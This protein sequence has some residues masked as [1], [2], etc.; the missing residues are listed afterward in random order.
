MVRKARNSPVDALGLDN[1]PPAAQQTTRMAT[2]ELLALERLPRVSG[3]L[4]LRV[5]PPWAW[6]GARDRV[7]A[8]D[9]ARVGQLQVSWIGFHG[10]D[11]PSGKLPGLVD[12][13][14]CE[15]FRLIDDGGR[16]GLVAVDRWL[17]LTV[18][19]A[20]VG[21]PPP[22]AMR[23]L[24]PVERG[25]LGGHLAALLAR[26]GTSITIDLSGPGSTGATESLIGVRL[27]AEV[28]GVAGTVRIHAPAQW[29]SLGRAAVRPR[30]RESP[31]AAVLL[32]TVATVELAVTTLRFDEL[33]AAGVGDAV[34]FDG[35]R[36]PASAQ[37]AVALRIGDHTAPARANHAGDVVLA[38]RFQAADRRL[39]ATGDPR[40]RA[41]VVRK[42]SAM[43]DDG[44]Q[45][46]GE[47]T[48]AEL[49]AAAPIEIVA[50][51]GRIVL[52]GDEVLGLAEG[53]VLSFGRS[54]T[55]VELAV[56]GRIWARG[57]LVNVDGELGVR[58][59]ELVR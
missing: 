2:V 38:G 5:T 37:R 27:R 45:A 46:S 3:A 18:V 23:R 34:V 51:L 24:G 59:T 8:C 44:D 33:E 32:Y 4:G 56:G 41:T 20:T 19:A 35:Y 7:V 47:G 6:A 52:R 14:G 30:W 54:G 9:L 39:R 36:W 29:L 22:I 49:L 31:S 15:R 55:T 17:A 1:Q 11:Q 13:G 42:T 25:V 16:A 50:E 58:I 57:E 53:S 43:S 26:W 28:G 12:Q 10:D 40:A 21:L 48:N